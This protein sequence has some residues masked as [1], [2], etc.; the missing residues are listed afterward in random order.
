MVVVVDITILKMASKPVKLQKENPA[1]YA[2][3]GKQSKRNQ[4]K[5]KGRFK[6][7]RQNIIPQQMI[8][9]SYNERPKRERFFSIKKNSIMVIKIFKNY[10]WISNKKIQHEYM[11]L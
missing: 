1:G 6:D 3:E 10:H 8:E 11:L 7:K 2:E 9:K 4:E 5:R